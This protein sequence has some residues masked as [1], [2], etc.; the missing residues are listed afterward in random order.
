M[1]TQ[2]GQAWAQLGPEG[3]QG[4]CSPGLVTVPFLSLSLARCGHSSQLDGAGHPPG[5]EA[6]GR[7]PGMA[8]EV[9]QPALGLL[10]HLWILWLSHICTWTTAASKQEFF[11]PKR[12]HRVEF[13]TSKRTISSLMPVRAAWFSWSSQQDC[14]SAGNCSSPH[15]TGNSSLCHASAPS[16]HAPNPWCSLPQTCPIL[17]SSKHPPGSAPM[18]LAHP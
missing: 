5:A 7:S 17:C 1:P 2:P 8:R 13:L 4:E 6:L 12:G 14:L 11:A 10:L 15:K 3:L 18:P 9:L 16:G